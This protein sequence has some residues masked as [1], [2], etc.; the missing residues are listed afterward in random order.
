[1]A[2]RKV[3][4]KTL[5]ATKVPKMLSAEIILK[6]KELGAKQIVIWNH[7][8]SDSID[9]NPNHN[10]LNKLIPADPKIIGSINYSANIS[11]IEKKLSSPVPDP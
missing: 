6:L 10:D 2:Q 1:M 4:L 11:A 8:D 9:I 3:K 7:K 5:E